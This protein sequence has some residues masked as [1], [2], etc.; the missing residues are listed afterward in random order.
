MPRPSRRLHSPGSAEVFIPAWRCPLGATVGERSQRGRVLAQARKR[1]AQQTAVAAVPACPNPQS[2]G[3]LTAT[4][5]AIGPEVSAPQAPRAD[6]RLVRTQLARGWPAR[7]S[8]KATIQH[9]D[10]AGASLRFATPAVV[11]GAASR[12]IALRG[13]R[14]CRGSELGRPPRLYLPSACLCFGDVAQLRVQPT[15][16]GDEQ[17]P[18]RWRPRRAS[19]IA[20]WEQ[21][22]ASAGDD[23]IRSERPPSSS[24]TRDTDGRWPNREVSATDEASGGPT[25]GGLTRFPQRQSE[26]EGGC[27]PRVRSCRSSCGARGRA[28][29]RS[30]VGRGRLC[31]AHNSSITVRSRPRGR[32]GYWNRGN[33]IVSADPRGRLQVAVA[34]VRCGVGGA[35]APR[36]A[37]VPQPG[38]ARTAGVPGWAGLLVCPA[39]PAASVLRRRRCWPAGGQS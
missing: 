32:R 7:T 23:A 6:E 1:R 30:F 33:A 25:A 20:E 28:S 9:S 12:T 27:R 14:S 36:I 5:P 35:I 4:P 26:W 37:I 10:G 39:D 38:A 15:L 18:V 21:A 3:S 34:L 31:R 24:G 13:A 19:C 11:R 16:A 17:A 22:P 2:N 29:C 8:A